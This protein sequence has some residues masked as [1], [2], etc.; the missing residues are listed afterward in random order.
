MFTSDDIAT[1][2]D[3]LSWAKLSAVYVL[4]EKLR[5]TRYVVLLYTSPSALVVPTVR[6]KISPI[7][8]AI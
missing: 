5:M 3:Y 2:F 8:I 6:G 4:Y 7:Q 1:Q